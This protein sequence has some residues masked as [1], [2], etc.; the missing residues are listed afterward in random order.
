[1]SSDWKTL[2]S[3][4]VYKNPWLKLHEDKV[5]TPSGEKMLYSWYESADVVVVVP[6]LDDSTIVMINQYR[7]P[8]HKALLEFPAG[9][10]K[11]GEN[12][13]DTA[14]R[15]LAEETGYHFKGINMFIHIIHLLAKPDRLYMFTKQ[16]S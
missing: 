2:E 8:L 11:N 6:F 4:V 10:I 12:P 7:Y 14:V 3:R 15:E 5:R 13:H 1:M 9:H 16:K